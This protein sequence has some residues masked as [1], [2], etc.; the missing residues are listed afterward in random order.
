MLITLVCVVIGLSV[1]FLLALQLQHWVD[2][3]KDGV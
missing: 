2:D 3:A 1:A